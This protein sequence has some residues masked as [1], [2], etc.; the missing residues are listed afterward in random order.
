MSPQLDLVYANSFVCIFPTPKYGI[1]FVILLYVTD[2]VLK[3]RQY[4]LP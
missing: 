1:I 2:K 4:P 3:E